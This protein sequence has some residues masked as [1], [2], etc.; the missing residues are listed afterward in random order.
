MALFAYVVILLPFQSGFIIEYGN[1]FHGS[2]NAIT[3][4]HCY[5][6]LKLFSI[7]QMTIG[8]QN[9]DK[10]ILMTPYCLTWRSTISSHTDSGCC[11]SKRDTVPAEE[12]TGK[13]T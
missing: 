5:E 12:I 8:F 2:Y 9:R 11:W 4:F 7:I 13:Q 3:K 10:N 1:I 6:F